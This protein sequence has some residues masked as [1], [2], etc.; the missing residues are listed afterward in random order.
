MP[1]ASSDT[2]LL[3]MWVRGGSLALIHVFHGPAF[4]NGTQTHRYITTLLLCIERSIHS[5]KHTVTSAKGKKNPRT[6][7]I[8]SHILYHLNKMVSTRRAQSDK[9][10]FPAD[11]QVGDKVEVSSLARWGRRMIHIQ[12]TKACSISVSVFT[13]LT[14]S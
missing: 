8:L 1:F 14:V 9:Q 11:Y 6:S 12:N 13:F 5:T 10:R 3:E 7:R 2:S 4:T